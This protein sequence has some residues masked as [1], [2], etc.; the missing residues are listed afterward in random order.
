MWRKV[1]DIAQKKEVII[2]Y[3]QGMPETLQ[4]K[5]TSDLISTFK[6]SSMTSDIILTPHGKTLAHHHQMSLK[7]TRLSSSTRGEVSREKYFSSH[8]NFATC[9]WRGRRCCH[10]VNSI[11]SHSFE[12]RELRLG[13]QLPHLNAAKRSEGI[14]WN[15]I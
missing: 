9:T 11:Y 15:F 4:V 14:F 6:S 10:S 1:S 5:L 13:T 8:Y 3:I 12:A 2:C 7:C